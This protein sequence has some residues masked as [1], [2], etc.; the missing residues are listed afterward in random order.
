MI[1]SVVEHAFL[2][3]FRAG[4]A[5]M[6]GPLRWLSLLRLLRNFSEGTRVNVVSEIHEHADPRKVRWVAGRLGRLEKR[7]KAK[8]AARALAGLVV[9]SLERKAA[10]MAAAYDEDRVPFLSTLL[11]ATSARCNLRCV[12]CPSGSAPADGA[13]TFERLDGIVRQAERLHLFHVVVMGKGE[14][15]FDEACTRDLCRLIERHRFLN[16]IVFTNGTTLGEDDVRRLARMENLFLFVSLDGPEEINDER[17]GKGTYRRAVG[18]MRLLRRNG[19]LF[20]YSTT[21]HRLNWQAALSQAFVSSMAA[22]GCLLG[23]YIM[24]APVDEGAP[25]E[26]MLGPREIEAYASRL[27]A[28]N[29][30]VDIPLFD[31]EIA[32]GIHGCRAKRGSMIYVDGVTGRVYPCPKMP[33]SAPSCSLYDR[34]GENRLRVILASDFFAGFRKG[35]ST[36]RPCTAHFDEEVGRLLELGVSGREAQQ[37]ATLMTKLPPGAEGGGLELAENS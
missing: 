33:F 22:E 37:I 3:A 13:P 15:F 35:G 6:P 29:A 24:Y 26:L 17:R 1:E 21:A 27:R 18:L 16:F 20:G 7:R 28:V 23:T 36:Q 10:R 9:R 14:P 25:G 8:L 2:A 34:P 32:E 31:F 11:L 4:W 5:F 19:L 30:A 12:G